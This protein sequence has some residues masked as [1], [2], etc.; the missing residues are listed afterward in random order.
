MQIKNTTADRMLRL[1]CSLSG[2]KCSMRRAY[3]LLLHGGGVCVCRGGVER[4]MGA[5]G[6]SFTSSGQC[7]YANMTE[8]VWMH[9]WHSSDALL[10]AV[11]GNGG[12]MG[13]VIDVVATASLVRL[14]MAADQPGGRSADPG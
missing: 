4:V 14:S 12:G 13:L 7:M 10:L 9:R 11:I 2:I 8:C 3:T 1:P 6:Q 5:P